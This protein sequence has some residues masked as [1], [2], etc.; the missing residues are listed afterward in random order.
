LRWAQIKKAFNKDAMLQGS[1]NDPMVQVVAQLSQ[2]S[3]HLKD[4]H[5][6]IQE[7]VENGANI[8]AAQPTKKSG[9]GGISF[10]KK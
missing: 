5:S 3:D 4:I 9:G 2:F 8:P 6:S 7:G 1:K 10:R